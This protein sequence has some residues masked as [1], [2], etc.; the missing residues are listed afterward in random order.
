MRSM[1]RATGPGPARAMALC[2]SEWITMCLKLLL[3]NQQSVASTPAYPAYI[4]IKAG[5]SEIFRTCASNL[6]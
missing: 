6:D 1:D 5:Y 3:Q 2:E 4:F